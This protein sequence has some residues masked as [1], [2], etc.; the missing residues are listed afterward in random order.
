MLS[1]DATHALAAI[2]VVAHDSIPD[3]RAS[4]TAWTLD[5][6]VLRWAK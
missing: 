1:L 4:W 3:G 2:V 6:L 5:P